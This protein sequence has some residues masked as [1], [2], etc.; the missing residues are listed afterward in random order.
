MNQLNS[1]RNKFIAVG[2]VVLLL[3]FQP[4]S[5]LLGP[6]TND[7]CSEL[8]QVREI[9]SKSHICAE[10]RDKELRWLINTPPSDENAAIGLILRS[11]L[12][13]YDEDYSIYVYPRMMFGAL[14]ERGIASGDFKPQ[15]EKFIQY[16]IE[17]T[18]RI[19]SNLEMAATLDQKWI[20][21]NSLWVSGIDS[22]YSRWNRGGVN[23]IEAI[24]ASTN[25]LDSIEGLSKIALKSGESEALKENRNLSDW[26]ARVAKQFD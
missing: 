2:V 12:S 10:A 23:Q 22:A 3:L 20:R 19:T 11:F 8:N 5:S 17:Q 18:R 13:N 1:T 25:N 21:I 6:E 9:K 16:D 26:I 15:N 24:N 7:S 4:I 14:A